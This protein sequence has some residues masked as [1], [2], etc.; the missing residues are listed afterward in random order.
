MDSPDEVSR[1]S[2]AH[3]PVQPSSSTPPSLPQTPTQTPLYIPTLAA[4]NLWAPTYD[5][6]SNFLQALD[7]LLIPTLLPHLINTLPPAPKLIDLGCGTGRNTLHLL[8]IPNAEVTGLD[9]ST[10]MLQI[11]QKRCNQAWTALPAEERAAT[12]G[13]EEWD[14][15]SLRKDEG[16]IP[17]AA[18]GTD[19]I[20]STLVLEHVPL[21]LFFAACARVLKP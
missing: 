4:Y 10:A 1:E 8:H 19:A 13:F 6:D 5:T 14:I 7:S 15:F 9:N 17:Q 12:I 20:I 16:S 2:I 3:P 11:A 21:P 18:K